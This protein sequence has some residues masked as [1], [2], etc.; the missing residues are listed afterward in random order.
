MR[1]R[2]PLHLC[3]ILDAQP[4]PIEEVLRRLPIG[5]GGEPE[6]LQL[7]AHGGGGFNPEKPKWAPQA[8]AVL[9]LVDAAKARRP[10]DGRT[11]ELHLWGVAPL[12]L[13]V[14]LGQALQDWDGKITFY[15]P[16]GNGDW[17]IIPIE[18]S[19]PTQRGAVFFDVV[20]PL[21]IL[22]EETPRSVFLS[23]RGTTADLR[24][25]VRYRTEQHQPEGPLIQLRTRAYRALNR[26]SAARVVREL[27][28]VLPL[29]FGPEE[30][31]AAESLRA[32]LFLETSEPLA[33][34]VGRALPRGRRID[35]PELRE[36]RYL[37]A[38]SL[39]WARPIRRQEP[40]SV[41]VLS[42]SLDDDNIHE[43][44]LKQLR[45][46]S[47]RVLD[48]NH[49][50]PGA[51]RE[52]ELR[53]KLEE[54]DLIVPLLSAEFV[55]SALGRELAESARYENRLVP[56]LHRSFPIERTR[57][58]GLAF[59]P[60]DGIPLSERKDSDAALTAVAR[61]TVARA[62]QFESHRPRPI[63]SEDLAPSRPADPPL[64]SDLLDR[65]E[66]ELL[67][68][69]RLRFN[70]IRRQEIWS[71][72]FTIL[73]TLHP[74][75]GLTERMQAPFERT[76]DGDALLRDVLALLDEADARRWLTLGVF[77][78]APEVSFNH[79]G[80]L[81][82]AKHL[83][84]NYG[85]ATSNFIENAHEKVSVVEEIHRRRAE[86]LMAALS[87]DL[88]EPTWEITL[89]LD[90]LDDFRK[91][92]PFPDD[93]FRG[94]D[95]ATITS[96]ALLNLL[97]AESLWRADLQ[98]AEHAY[99][100]A[101]ERAAEER[102]PLAEW[103]AILGLSQTT[104]W[105]YF[106]WKKTLPEQ[107]RTVVD[108]QAW[109]RRQQTLE[110]ESLVRQVE[111]HENITV[112]NVQREVLES[113]QREW[114]DGGRRPIQIFELRFLL[115][116]LG[117]LGMPPVARGNVAR[118]LGFEIL[119]QPSPED[120]EVT[121]AVSILCIHGIDQRE[122][123][124][125]SG[126]GLR[127]GTPAF[128]SAFRWVLQTPVRGVGDW[129][130]RIGFLNRHNLD[131]PILLQGDV[132][133]FCR[134][135]LDFF[136]GPD[137]GDLLHFRGTA[138][139]SI[140]REGILDP[141]VRQSLSFAGY[142]ENGVDLLLDV[143]KRSSLCQKLAIANLQCIDWDAWYESACPSIERLEAVG[144]QVIA[145]LEDAMLPRE[146]LREENIPLGIASLLRM[147]QRTGT[148]RSLVDSLHTRLCHLLARGMAA[149]REDF[150]VYQYVLFSSVVL[151]WLKDRTDAQSQAFYCRMID[152][153][154]ERLSTYKTHSGYFAGY[155]CL[156]FAFGLLSTKQ[157]QRVKELLH[158]HRAALLHDIGR[159]LYAVR[160]LLLFAVG[161][162]ET[163]DD[164]LCA[165]G[166]D[167]LRKSYPTPE[168]MAAAVTAAPQQTKDEQEILA[169]A[170]LHCLRGTADR[171]MPW[172][173]SPLHFQR[174]DDPAELVLQGLDAVFNRFLLQPASPPPGGWRRFLDPCLSACFD[175][176][177][178]IARRGLDVVERALHA[179]IQE[180]ELL[181]VVRALRWALGR[182]HREVRDQALYI[183][184]R[185]AER[186]GPDAGLE[187]ACQQLLAQPTLSSERIVRLAR[188]HKGGVTPKS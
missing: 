180:L 36:G 20:D 39:P 85:P 110:N 161:L 37:R 99:R 100:L 134:R 127:V 58:G 128:A 138:F 139:G 106:Q 133:K 174:S 82:L 59:I 130:A 31:P 167:L 48:G 6:R 92:R 97:G 65:M 16:H 136:A 179:N 1:P 132:H 105:H 84:T 126:P 157:W 144:H 178:R 93:V 184:L 188:Q 175:Q 186:L 173:S 14:L 158:V 22:D 153:Q 30:E 129:E 74:E 168:G 107:K 135:A 63:R 62:E 77:H 76:D 185:F 137:D 78:V 159:R 50:T 83:V 152:A 53:K 165:L 96:A 141:L 123:W 170:V 164:E 181:S 154:I 72:L 160:P 163:G 64:I 34:L 2:G 89:A 69:P 68:Q 91:D 140:I 19:L 45:S 81:N 54:A 9:S 120:A 151:D 66:E 114:A 44:L 122:D 35:V 176:N 7:S 57:W 111:R 38:L 86:G 116:D 32:T 155:E 13:F 90:V 56:V 40:V 187:D 103:V 49:F 88:R 33:F 25:I 18:K 118:L 119:R 148:D 23:T 172:F 101:Q 79:I 125:L 21:P 67:L 55:S 95:P 17:E 171:P 8:D 108:R 10:R 182:P 150:S 117:E 70:K 3:V 80:T 109:T 4:T 61:A 177:P 87:P 98:T 147:L 113:V 162:L 52:Q 166:R 46:V 26:A 149:E 104:R 27:T 71:K 121:E 156:S 51:E 15:A 43:R 146:I 169:Q 94:H 183:A 115:H 29:A 28:K 143:L 131:L 42:A 11:I 12:P 124:R 112:L 47:I 60:E 5:E 75:R 102:Q 142:V 145:S 73:Q 41:L 24:R